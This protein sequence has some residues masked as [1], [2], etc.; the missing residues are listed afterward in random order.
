MS[1]IHHVEVGQALNG[2]AWTR[3]HVVVGLSAG[4]RLETTVY[5][6]EEEQAA[7]QLD[8]S[9]PWIVHDPGDERGRL[10]VSQPGSVLTIDRRHLHLIESSLLGRVEPIDPIAQAFRAVKPTAPR[11][12]PATRS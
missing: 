3:A 5:V 10:S 11:A 8:I 1:D 4:L 12:E 9:G 7:G 6:S 2:P